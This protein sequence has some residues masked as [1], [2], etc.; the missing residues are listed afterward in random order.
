MK[1][2]LK[3]LFDLSFNN[4]VAIHIVRVTFIIGCLVGVISAV[5]CSVTLDPSIPLDEDGWPVDFNIPLEAIPAWYEV[6]LLAYVLPIIMLIV[7]IPT[8]RLSLEMYVAL[9]R[10]AENTTKLVEMMDSKEAL[11][12]MRDDQTE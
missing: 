7:Y 6:I 10:I 11:P 5:Y 8:L 12:V 1:S 4:F 2:F 9:V 3:N